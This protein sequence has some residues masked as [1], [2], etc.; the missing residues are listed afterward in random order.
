MRIALCEPFRAPAALASA[1][2]AEV[3]GVGA[4]EI[5][6][7]ATHSTEVRKNDLFVALEGTRCNG[8]TYAEEALSRGAAAVLAAADVPLDPAYPRFLC[9]SPIA[10]LSRAAA[11]W[12][13]THRGRLI[14]VGGSA[15][16]TTVKEAVATLL[17]QRCS[18]ARS[19]GNFNSTVGLP[20]S[21]LAFEQCDVWVTELGISHPGEMAAL[22]RMAAPDLAVLTNVG[23]AHIGQFEDGAQL[24]KEKLK[25]AACLQK[26]GHFLIP[27]GLQLPFLPCEEKQIVRFGGAAPYRL[28]RVSNGESGVSGDLI[29]PD[30]LI[31]NISWPIAG[32]IGIAVLETVASIGVL[33]GLSDIEIRRGIALAAAETPRMRL[34]EAGGFCLIDD[35]YNAS[36]EAMLR[37]LEA[38]KHRA[39]ARPAVAVLGDML[40]LGS[41]SAR[42]HREVGE[43]V[44]KS[45]ISMLLTYG[46]AALEIA[47]AARDAGMPPERI[48]PF[49][50]DEREALLRT[51]CHSLPQGAAVLFKASGKMGLSRLAREVA[52]GL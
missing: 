47:R 22:S 9:D 43:A 34:V 30:R 48:L 42:C 49:D 18:V 19:E 25:I 4:S 40:E 50:S 38:L 23:R 12:R 8:A 11:R 10:A 24:L 2:G 15:G 39:G 14:A 29:T 26:N 35:A 41:H 3:I 21:L 20:L 37:A 6:G 46:R 33:L 16:K 13:R 7:V 51:L 31:T 45:D 36:P 28:V 17:S 27:F 44:A 1:L 5:G 52:Q 32:E